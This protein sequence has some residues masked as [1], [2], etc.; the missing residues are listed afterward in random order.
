PTNKVTGGSLPAQTWR[1]FMLAATQ[2]M[3]VRPLPAAP[4][5]PPRLVAATPPGAGVGLFDNFFGLFGPS[6]R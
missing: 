5:P 3:P 6:Q 2:G 1:W 4:A